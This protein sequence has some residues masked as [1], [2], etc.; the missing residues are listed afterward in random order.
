MA[1]A[2]ALLTRPSH[3]RTLLLPGLSCDLLLGRFLL[4][5]LL[6]PFSGL[7]LARWNSSASL[8]APPLTPPAPGDLVH[9]HSFCAPFADGTESPSLALSSAPS[10]RQGLEELPPWP[11]L[12]LKLSIAR[13]S[14]SPLIFSALLCGV[15]LTLSPKLQAYDHHHWPH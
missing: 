1:T 6:S 7:L 13:W 14:S 2:C 4:E 9:A 3:P 15:T 12:H 8:P 5:P 11:P 10:Q